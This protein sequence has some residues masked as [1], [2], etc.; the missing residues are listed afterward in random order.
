VQTCA[1]VH[2][3]L[4]VCVLCGGTSVPVRAKL[5]TWHGRLIHTS[6]PLHHA[7]NNIEFKNR[8]FGSAL[9]SVTRLLR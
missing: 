6:L 7:G 8:C 1:R 9:S 2:V 4:C 3:S 5:R